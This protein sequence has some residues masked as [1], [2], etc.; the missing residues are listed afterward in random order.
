M[1]AD[2]TGNSEY[3]AASER[4]AEWEP[5]PEPEREPELEPQPEPELELEPALQRA[6][7]SEAAKPSERRVL[8]CEKS[9]LCTWAGWLRCSAPRITCPSNAPAP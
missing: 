1:T 2:V 4:E 9:E 8:P 3:D 5:E 7:R 6:A